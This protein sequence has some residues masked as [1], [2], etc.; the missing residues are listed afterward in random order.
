MAKELVFDSWQGQDVLPLLNN[1]QT[2]SGIHP[3]SYPMGIGVFL[4]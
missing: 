4:P 2:G 3:V 1:I